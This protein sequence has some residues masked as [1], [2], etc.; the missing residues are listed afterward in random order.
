[1]ANT[2]G[3]VRDVEQSHS[4]ADEYIHHDHIGHGNTAAAWA[5]N[6]IIIVASLIAAVGF[7]IEVWTLV[8]IA[9][10]LVPVAL[11]VG[12]AMKRAGYGVEEDSAAVIKGGADPREHSGPAVGNS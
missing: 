7:I 3:T 6:G 4:A 8:W 2:Q 12:F 10:A 9:A 5:L 1:M 11:I